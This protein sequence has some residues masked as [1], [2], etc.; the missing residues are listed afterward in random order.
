LR[1]WEM[2]VSGLDE[3]LSAEKYTK[4]I[5]VNKRTLYKELVKAST[6]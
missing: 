1:L 4:H 2:R 5:Y 6:A 3:M